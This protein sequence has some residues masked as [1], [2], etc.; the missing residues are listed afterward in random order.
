MAFTLVTAQTLLARNAGV[1]YGLQLGTVDMAAYSL[2]MG[3]TTVTQA[4]FLNSV[5][6]ASVG[7]ATVAAVAAQVVTGVGM[8]HRN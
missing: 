8:L 2:Q 4:A 1:L 5:Y 7:S 3:T 6:A